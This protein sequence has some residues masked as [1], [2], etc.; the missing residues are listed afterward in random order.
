MVAQCLLN[1]VQGVTL[2]QSTSVSLLTKGCVCD[3]VK[4][5]ALCDQVASVGKGLIACLPL[6]DHYVHNVCIMCCLNMTMRWSSKWLYLLQHIDT[7]GTTWGLSCKAAY[8]WNSQSHFSG[9]FSPP[10]TFIIKLKHIIA[11]TS[12]INLK[13]KILVRQKSIHPFQVS[14]IC[15]LK[16]LAIN[17]IQLMWL[18]EHCETLSVMNTFVE[19]PA[20]LSH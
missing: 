20:S 2:I 7:R 15:C 10:M 19:S 5:R 12:K 11:L 17:S 6:H 4:C 8:F 3:I 18:W 9:E 1:A 16:L 13:N 14:Q